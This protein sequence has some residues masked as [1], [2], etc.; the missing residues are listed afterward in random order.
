MSRIMNVGL[1]PL[2]V[3]EFST[4]VRLK[5]WCCLVDCLCL[6]LEY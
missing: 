1:R 4:L 5:I 2:R 3:G 6:L